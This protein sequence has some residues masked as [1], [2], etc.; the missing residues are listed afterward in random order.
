MTKKGFAAISPD[1]QR[2]I[3]AKGGKAAHEQGKAHE[4]TGDEARAAGRKG[5]ETISKDREHMAAIG[6]KG[7]AARAESVRRSK[8]MKQWEA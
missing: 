5:G 2:A 1:K 8:A 3:A 4:W 7:A 6:R